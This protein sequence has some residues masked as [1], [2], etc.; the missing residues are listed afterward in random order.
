ME[1]EYDHDLYIDIDQLE[2]EW[3]K[4]PHLYMKYSEMVAD[5][6]KDA[7][8]AKEKVS[9]KYAELDNH[10]REMM[11]ANGEKITEKLV[12][13]SVLQHEAYKKALSTLNKRKHEHAILQGALR[14]IDQRKS[15]LENLVRLALGGYY[16]M[17]VE[18]KS[19]ENI[20]ERALDSLDEKVRDQLNKKRS[21]TNVKKTR[22]RKKQ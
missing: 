3:L 14:A 6:G 20:R 11:K 17:P 10:I 16:S 2:I 9:L 7:D 19:I 8:E 18:P 21:R 12:E 4:Q 1:N 13:A 22:Q 15:A 5:A